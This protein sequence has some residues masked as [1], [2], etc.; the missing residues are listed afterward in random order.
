MGRGTG[1]LVPVHLLIDVR[2]ACGERKTGK[3]HWTLHFVSTLLTRC[4]DA[5]LLLGR[6]DSSPFPSSVR[7]HVLPYRGLLWHV[8]A[9]RYARRHAGSIY[10]SPTSYIVPA[11]LSGSVPCIPVVHDLIAFRPE[12]HE[13]RARCIERLTLYRAASRAAGLCTLSDATR[14]DVLSRYPDIPPERV[15]TIGAGPVHAAP[16]AAAQGNPSHILCAAT[17]CPRKN[18]LTLIRAYDALPQSLRSRFPLMLAG[19]RGWQDRN[20]V[21]AARSTAGVRWAGYSS[22]SAMEELYR[23]AAVVACPSLYEGFGLPVL[24]ALQRGIPVLCSRRG[25]LAEVA[26]DAA[27][28]VDPESVWSV[29]DG[30]LRLLTDSTLRDDLRRRGLQRAQQFTW[31]GTVDR[32]LAF[33]R[34]ISSSPACT[35]APRAGMPLQP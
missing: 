1:I 19:G 33:L 25:S 2:D 12:P 18:Q 22:D 23:D 21:R 28:F 6:G 20:I 31:E 27:V 4:S 35:P 34:D 10:V 30:L 14:S 26:G 5:T 9:A 3:G 24:T 11:L 7:T 17:L 13:L 32:F 8:H 29:R 16:D 15:R